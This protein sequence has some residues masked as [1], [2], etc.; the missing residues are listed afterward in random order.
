[1]SD[2]KVSV[3]VPV[4][5]VEKYIERCVRSLFEQTVNEG[6]EFVFVD[7]CTQDDSFDI[8]ER[9]LNEY[10]DRKSQVT[11]IRHIENKGLAQARVTG[12]E[13][14]RGEYVMHCDSDDYLC[15]DTLEKLLQP[16]IIDPSYDIVSGSVNSIYPNRIVK[17]E[18]PKLTDPA[19]VAKCMIMRH[20]PCNIWNR[21]IRRSLYKNLE[22]PNINN[23]EDYVT[24]CRLFKKASKIAN[25]EAITYNYTHENES[26]FQKSVLLLKNIVDL[27]LTSTFLYKY[28][29][30]DTYMKECIDIGYLQNVAIIM[31]AHE[32]GEEIK[33]IKIPKEYKHLIFNKKL[34]KM[35]L[36]FLLYK[37]KCFWLIPIVWKIHMKLFAK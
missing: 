3:C 11:I 5:G 16:I 17:I 27:E 21:L 33:N 10:P 1:M 13:H 6:I 23:G 4:F 32:T 7:D 9:V 35:R 20:I 34:G 29:S 12:I 14:A 24:T 22:I 25:I 28:F 18:S 8:L 19:E 30:E 15:A 2:I 37:L 26:S 36:I 31:C